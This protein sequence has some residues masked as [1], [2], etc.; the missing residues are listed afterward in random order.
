MSLFGHKKGIQ[1]NL[2]YDVLTKCKCVACP[3]QT[4]SA[5]AKPKI[6]A[7]N[8]MLQNPSK[9]M[10][11][12]M[13]PGMMRNVEMLQNMDMSRMMSMSREEQKKMSD[14]M[15][16]NTPKEETDKMMPKA[17]DLPGPYCSNG[18]AFCKDL[19]FTKTCICSSCQ[20]FKDFSL[21]KGKP[22]SY[23]CKNGKPE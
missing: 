2:T 17:E 14:E 7:R 6:D 19:D 20:V 5:C 3:V 9:M 13:S 11:Q 15:M 8:E 22:T 18:V 10:Q 12:I 4:N 23:Y 16:K 1:V 21:G